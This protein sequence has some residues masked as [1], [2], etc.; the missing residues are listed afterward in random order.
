[1]RRSNA[2]DILITV[3]AVLILSACQTSTPIPTA[4]LFPTTTIPT[5]LPPATPAPQ[6]P[7]SRAD[8]QRLDFSST[9]MVA[10]PGKLDPGAALQ[11]VFKGEAG[12]AVTIKA[13]IESVGPGVMSLW[14]ADGVTLI[15]EVSG[16]T[17]WEGSFPTTQDYYLNLKNG[18]A[19]ALAYRLTVKM[20][21]LATPEAKRIQFQPGSTG[22]TTHG[23]LPA[24][25]RARFVL[26]AA[27]GQQMTVT[28]TTG[29]EDIDSYLYIWSA[30]G[31]VFTLT[32]PSKEWSGLLPATQDYFIELVSVSDQA[33]TYQLTI[34]IPPAPTPQAVPTKEKV[35]G[36][37]IA[38]DQI[39]RFDNGPLEYNMDGAVLNGERDRYTLSAAT[40]ETMVVAVT[41]LEDNAVFTILG[42]DGKAIPGTEEGKDTQKWSDTL[43]NDGTYSILVGPTRGNAAYTLTITITL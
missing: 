13:A 11:V 22:G 31:S 17:E 4:T 34:T 1:M 27:A 19:N 35:E 32:A 16:I 9:T 40:G 3:L 2:S 20:P 41:S 21:P 29:A 5:P 38:K 14:G 24:K 39:I 18:G 42:P 36:P 37:N 25:E 10:T 30:D 8:A 28:L 23:D 26:R 7:E 6:H 43:S 12:R 33:L 15:P